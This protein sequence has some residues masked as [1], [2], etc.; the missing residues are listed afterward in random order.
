LFEEV[1]RRFAARL[2]RFFESRGFQRAD[3]EDLT[4]QVFVQVMN[5]KHHLG[6]SRASPWEPARG[7]LWTWMRRIAH[8]LACDEWARRGRQSQLPITAPTNGEEE[9]ATL[10]AALATEEP[11][12]G[13]LAIAAE[14]RQA[15]H[16]CLQRL[17]PRERTAIEQWLVAGQNPN[18]AELAEALGCSV[19]TAHRIV[20]RALDLMRQCL[21][22]NLEP[23]T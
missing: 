22:G 10:D 14:R 15:V 11:G 1:V 12:P 8:H 17:P 16:D 7:S 18:L 9:T 4:Q 21:E 20:Y 3:A 2:V 23:G 13:D 6:G 19:P 5:T